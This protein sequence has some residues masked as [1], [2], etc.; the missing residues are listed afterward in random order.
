[1]YRLLLFLKRIYLLV[2]FLGLEGVALYYYANSTERTRA[3]LL[4]GS[5]NLV[6]GVYEGIA[7]VE[8]YLS[9]GRTNRL[10]E[11][12]LEGLENAV[13]RM[14]EREAEVVND[15]LEM[16]PRAPLEY[17]VA[18]VVR[19]SVGKREN[20]MMVD[21]GAADGVERGM[22]AVSLDGYMAGYVES[23]S[24]NNAI[25]VSVLNTE[26][27]ASGMLKG[28]HF[29]S[30]TWRG[31]DPR[32]V[33]LNEVP[34]YAEVGRGDTV[35]TSGY[36]FSFPEGIRIGTVETYE[37]DEARAAYEIDVKLGLDVGALR[38]VLLVENPAVYERIKL[39]E[40]VLGEVEL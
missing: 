31:T 28:G 27:R 24:E 18:R 37:V 23:V 29:G 35:V 32:M 20:Y 3:Q 25:C 13:A 14:R 33:R 40:E 16:A 11:E 6:G 7:R 1:M 17:V 15:T 36:S 10:L 5:S 39:E 30:I 19:N 38:V 2:I 22:A 4:D 9:L 21:R 8:D 12:R 34:A 26:F